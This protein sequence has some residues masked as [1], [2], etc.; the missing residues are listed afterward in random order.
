MTHDGLKPTMGP[1]FPGSVRRELCTQMDNT[2]PNDVA[3]LLLV[4]RAV[5]LED[6]IGLGLS[7][8]VWVGVVE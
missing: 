6:V 7:R 3:D 4:R 1:G 2:Y 5:F 8:G